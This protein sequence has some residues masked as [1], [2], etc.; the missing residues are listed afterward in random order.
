[1]IFGQS[2]A[3]DPTRLDTRGVDFA[4]AETAYE[5]LAK[6]ERRGLAVIF[7]YDSAAKG[8]RSLCLDA[9]VRKAADEVG[10]AFIGAGNYAKAILLPA[11][12]RCRDA[13]KLHV[14]TATG[15][16][17][18]RTAEKFGYARCATEPA[19]VFGDAEVDLVFVATQH[20]S[21]ASLA[22]AALRAGK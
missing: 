13:R 19:D 16:S 5:E 9:G 6:G 12:S 14:V 20:D 7:R 22:E 3:V 8:E 2:G 15:A 17:A 4:E 18:R 1:M 11:V 10:T 21:H